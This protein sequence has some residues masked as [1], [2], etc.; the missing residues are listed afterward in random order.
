MSTTTVEHTMHVS[1]KACF[2]AARTLAQRAVH[3]DFWAARA[4]AAE[5]VRQ[6]EAVTIKC[7]AVGIRGF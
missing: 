6:N 3:L 4:V 1:G 7:S 5:F 2:Q